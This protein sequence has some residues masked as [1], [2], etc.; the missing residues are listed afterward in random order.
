MTAMVDDPGGLNRRS[1]QH[2]VAVLLPNLIH[3]AK[4]W[5]NFWHPIVSWFHTSHLQFAFGDSD[6]IYVVMHY[7]CGK[8]VTVDIIRTDEWATGLWGWLKQVFDLRF[9]AGHDP[10]RRNPFRLVER[11][12]N[13]GGV[14][15]EDLAQL[16]LA[17][18]KARDYRRNHER[19]A[20][21]IPVGL[22]GRLQPG[23]VCI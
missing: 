10:S 9:Y 14:P 21:A 3:P 5:A 13:P 22:R 18:E 11:F 23:F 8:L 12:P 4:L 15:I 2:V 16:A 19:T 20:R 1:S 6:E 17:H 7:L